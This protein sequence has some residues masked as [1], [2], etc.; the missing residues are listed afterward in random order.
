MPSSVCGMA[1]LTNNRDPN[2]EV[3]KPEYNGSYLQLQHSDG[4]NVSMKS[5][6]TMQSANKIKRGWE[7]PKD[8]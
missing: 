8:V 4:Q 5:P 6:C 3:E 7:V 2:K 1:A